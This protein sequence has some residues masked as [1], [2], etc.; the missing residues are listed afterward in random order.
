[1]AN[2]NLLLNTSKV[3]N[4]GIDLSLAF[5]FSKEKWKNMSNW[6]FLCC[7]I[8]KCILYYYYYCYLLFVCLFHSFHQKK[9]V[10]SCYFHQNRWKG[11]EI[12]FNFV[13]TLL[14]WPMELNQCLK[15]QEFSKGGTGRR[16]SLFT[17][18]TDLTYRKKKGKKSVLEI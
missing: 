7:I 6:M 17:V 9:N 18:H 10:I 14:V 2:S 13:N 11:I 1:M 15:V 12:G 4:S 8:L 16:K 5:F 3:G